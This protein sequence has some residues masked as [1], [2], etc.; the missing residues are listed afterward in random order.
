MLSAM[1]YAFLVG[2][3][4]GWSTPT[5][6]HLRAPKCPLLSDQRLHTA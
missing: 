1:L 6:T 5:S 4:Y 2:P 3:E